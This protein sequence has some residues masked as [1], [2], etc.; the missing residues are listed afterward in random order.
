MNSKKFLIIAAIILL[1]IVG[2][3]AVVV[4][5]NSASMTAYYYGEVWNYQELEV[6]QNAKGML[7][8]C[9]TRPNESIFDPTTELDCY[10]TV[11]EA[12]QKLLEYRP[13][14]EGKLDLPASQD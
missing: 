1:I 9:V 6:E 7:L 10:D 3:T 4:A 12:N 5:R 2:I 8:Y 11:E 14:L 13:D